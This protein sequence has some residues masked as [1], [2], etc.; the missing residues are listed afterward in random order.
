MSKKINLLHGV[1]T[2]WGRVMLHKKVV[3]SVFL[4]FG[5]IQVSFSQRND[6]ADSLGIPKEVQKIIHVHRGT[7][8]NNII[9]DNKGLEKKL[10]LLDDSKVVGDTLKTVYYPNGDIAPF[11]YDKKLQLEGNNNKFVKLSDPFVNGKLLVIVFGDDVFIPNGYSKDN[12][13]TITGNCDKTKGIFEYFRK[14]SSLANVNSLEDLFK[15]I[16]SNSISLDGK[17][18]YIAK[19]VDDQTYNFFEKGVSEPTIVNVSSVNDWFTNQHI[20]VIVKEKYTYLNSGKLIGLEKKVNGKF[21]I[22]LVNNEDKLF[23]YTDLLNKPIKTIVSQDKNI[24]S[25]NQFHN[26]ATID[27][28]SGKVKYTSNAI[29]NRHEKVSYNNSEG[30]T[31]VCQ[32]RKGNTLI[33]EG[34]IPCLEVS[35]ELE[36]IGTIEIE[37]GTSDVIVEIT[38]E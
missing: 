19:Q 30:K 24:D 20:T 34:S 1:L 26:T 23:F 28:E 14:A 8:T 22:Y 2:L 13:P 3:V 10:Y 21:G 15:V 35:V 37:S 11:N 29:L 17:P 31:R 4:F 32:V 25:K 7:I 6:F 27:G 16:R 38:E 18:L 33:Y 5:T 9:I 12:D 36:G